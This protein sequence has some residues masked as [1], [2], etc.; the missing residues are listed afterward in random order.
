MGF[1]VKKKRIK[2]GK[3]T[4]ERKQGKE[5]KEKK[6]KEK[7]RKEKK[8]WVVIRFK[9]AWVGIFGGVTNSNKPWQ[10]RPRVEGDEY[11]TCERE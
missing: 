3:R 11:R 1:G 8:S 6:R 7:K 10:P 9:R 5:R 2:E 4:E